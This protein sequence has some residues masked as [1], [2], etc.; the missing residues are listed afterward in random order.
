MFTRRCTRET[1]LGAIPCAL[2]SRARFIVL[3]RPLNL[4]A[5]CWREFAGAKNQKYIE[6]QIRSI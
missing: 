4:P 2:A 5:P 3:A 6:M 1:V